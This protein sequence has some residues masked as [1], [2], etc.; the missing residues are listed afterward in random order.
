MVISVVQTYMNTMYGKQS[1]KHLSDEE[2]LDLLGNLT[3]YQSEDSYQTQA[4]FVKD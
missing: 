4:T 2:L 1:P 3:T